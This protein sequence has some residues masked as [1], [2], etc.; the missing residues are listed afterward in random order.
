M[1]ADNKVIDG[2]LDASLPQPTAGG[3]GQVL[4]PAAPPPIPEFQEF[5][6]FQRW[7]SFH[8]KSA[9]REGGSSAVKVEEYVAEIY[10]LLGA[11]AGEREW[12]LVRAG[13]L[14]RAWYTDLYREAD[15]ENALR[16]PVS[17]IKRVLEA[18]RPERYADL[19]ERLEG[20]IGGDIVGIR[21]SKDREGRFT[22]NGKSYSDNTLR[23]MV[24]KKK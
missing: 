14:L 24:S 20:A 3:A 4:E 19:V 21:V 8:L 17:P 5:S 6:S 18:V 11:G 12:K 1:A 7:M 16:R 10:R 2:T 15:L 22:L 23:V 13:Y 9:S